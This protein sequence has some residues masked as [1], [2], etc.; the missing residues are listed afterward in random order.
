MYIDT[1]THANL[2]QAATASGIECNLIK[3]GIY[4]AICKTEDCSDFPSLNVTFYESKISGKTFNLT[5][6]A[7]YFLTRV[8]SK[9]Y[10]INIMP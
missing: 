6:E 10:L 2:I 1:Q 4:F 3:N 7:K 9:E 8:S 5:L